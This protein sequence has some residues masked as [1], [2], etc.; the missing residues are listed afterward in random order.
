MEKEDSK[1]GRRVVLEDIGTVGKGGDRQN[2]RRNME[3]G[4]ATFQRMCLWFSIYLQIRF[5]I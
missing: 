4:P 1:S 2:R 3:Q 5:Q